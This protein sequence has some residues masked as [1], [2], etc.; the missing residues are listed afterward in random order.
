MIIASLLPQ[1]LSPSCYLSFPSFPKNIED[2]L[3]GCLKQTMEVTTFKDKSVLATSSSSP[4]VATFVLRWAVLCCPCRVGPELGSGPGA[5]E[6]ARSWGVGPK[7]WS[8]PGAGEWARSWG[9]GQELGVGP[10]LGSGPGAGEWARSWG[11]GQELG[12]GPGAGEWARSWGVG[13]AEC[14][15]FRANQTLLRQFSVSVWRHFLLETLFSWFS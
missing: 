1:L 2:S 6:W 8:G 12:S 10:E 7:L 14:H 9:V 5:G 4:A 13:W 3:R 15:G 11:V